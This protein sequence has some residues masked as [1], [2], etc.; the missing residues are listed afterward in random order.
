MSPRRAFAIILLL[1]LL[2]ALLYSVVI[3]LAE[4][5]DEADHYAYLS[6]IGLNWQLPQGTDMTQGKHPPLYHAAAAGLTAWTGLEWD[7]LRSNP[8]ALPLGPEK[9]PNL[10]VHTTLEDFPWRGGALA[11][12][13]ARFLSLLLGA[14][15]LWA[16]WRLGQTV[17]P[18]RPAVGLMA[19]GFLAGLPGFLFIS[20]VINND[21]AAGALGSLAILLCA[22]I[23][24]RG[25]A[26][27]F[28]VLLGLVLG[29]GLLS[30][31]G[32]LALWPLVALAVFGSWWISVR[33]WHSIW[34]PLGH[35]LVAWGLGLAVASPWLVRNWQLYGDPLA[36]ELVRATVDQR[37]APL[38][39]GDLVWLLWGFHRTFWGRFGGAGQVALPMAVYGLAAIFM[40]ALA[41]GAV[42][43]L[44][45]YGSRPL[46]SGLQR[47]SARLWLQLAL[48]ALAPLLTFLSIASYSAMALGTDQARLMWPAL[49]A[50]AVWVGMGICGAADWARS[51]RPASR[52]AHD[53]SEAPGLAGDGWLAIGITLV[54]AGFGLVVALGLIRP[55]FAPPAALASTDLPSQPPLAR[56]GE[57]LVLR[58]V[59]LPGEPLATGQPLALRLVWQ[60]TRLLDD[61]LRPTVRL[62]HVDGWLAAE[63]SHSPAGG[64]YATDR[65]QPGLAL[66][67][68]YLI[69]P[70]PAG[71][72]TYWVEVAVR[73]F[74]GDWLPVEPASTA[75]PFFTLGQVQFR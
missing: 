52:R 6:Y 43:F 34:R 20:G 60:A 9:P 56:F 54:M 31:V 50:I 39:P 19:A 10:F 17:F 11:M 57:G 30:K 3:P 69:M 49:A 4:A 59:E 47:S 62:V 12:H 66:A 21:N 13:L 72:G 64:R 42:Y 35:A 18:E 16:S 22:S 40:V 36:W 7:F 5:P 28:T 61:D 75:A 23:L 41:A 58:D 74:G 65:W 2:L 68:E 8:D 37:L 14:V 46:D 38:V 53:P 55:A 27:R 63:W 24:A 73:P 33:D 70:E 25:L 26:W 67:D 15:T 44:R 51:L 1:Y 32:T 29:L 71:A 48:L 45:R